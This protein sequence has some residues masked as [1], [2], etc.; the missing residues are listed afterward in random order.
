[1]AFDYKKEYKEFYM[2]ANKPSIVTVPK[3]NYIGRELHH[4]V[5]LYYIQPKFF[6]K[7]ILNKVSGLSHLR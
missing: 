2:P 6:H 5:R 7:F 4:I 3:M 1:M